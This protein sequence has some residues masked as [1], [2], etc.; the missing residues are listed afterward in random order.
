MRVNL[1]K[2]NSERVLYG[3]KWIANAGKNYLASLNNS[4]QPTSSWKKLINAILLFPITV[5]TAVTVASIVY[6][7]FFLNA[8]SAQKND[9]TLS[10]IIKFIAKIL[11]YIVAAVILIPWIISNLM[12]SLILGL[13][14]YS[15]NK[16]FFNQK[17]TS[18]EDQAVNEVQIENEQEYNKCIKEEVGKLGQ[19]YDTDQGQSDI[20][21]ISRVMKD[22]QVIDWTVIARVVMMISETVKE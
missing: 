16:D 20:E 9:S 6:T 14:F 2:K 13:I 18:I 10:K 22:E 17:N 11:I 4:T 3:T 21:V 5:P 12:T 19:Q 8:V 7:Y 15:I 1:S